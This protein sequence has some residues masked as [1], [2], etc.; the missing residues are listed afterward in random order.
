MTTIVSLLTLFGPILVIIILASALELLRPEAPR[1]KD[2]LRWIHSAVLYLSCTLLVF[3]VVPG[4]HLAVIRF[5]QLEN[6]GLLHLLAVPYAVAVAVGLLALDFSEWFAH[7]ILHRVSVLWRLHRIHHSDQHLD[8]AT[9]LRFHPIE[10]VLRY[11]IG[12][13]FILVLGIP[14]LS[15]VIFTIAV[16]VFNAWEHA[17]IRMPSVLRPLGHVIITP[18]MHRVHHSEKP[19]HMH[20]NYG[21]I[22]SIWDKLAGTKFWKTPGERL[23]YGL[24]AGDRSLRQDITL[25][26]LFF[27]PFRRST[28]AGNGARALDRNN[29]RLVNDDIDTQ[30]RR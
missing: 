14:A 23:T 25:A 21:V 3:L 8:I 16:L 6:W 10:A 9:S 28:T 29:H 24:G 11:L 19:E 15:V 17:N 4:G 22:F 13:A 30:E 26:K 2:T 27:E 5:T 7:F 1:K 20:R 12:I 18:E